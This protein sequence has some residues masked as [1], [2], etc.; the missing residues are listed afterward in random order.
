M[1]T[2]AGFAGP[3]V[4]RRAHR[5]RD[6]LQRPHAPER[7]R[8]IVPLLLL[9]AR[10]DPPVGGGSLRRAHRALRVVEEV[11]TGRHYSGEFKNLRKNLREFKENLRRI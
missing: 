7:R 8:M 2:A 1:T 9:P 6:A 10:R 3:G 5:V 4:A 11:N